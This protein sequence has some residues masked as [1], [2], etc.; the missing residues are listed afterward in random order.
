MTVYWTFGLDLGQRRDH[1]ALA[2]LAVDEDRL[3]LRGLE[4]FP[5]GVDDLLR[6]LRRF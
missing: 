1:S 6:S 2:C 5:L 3:V 4:R